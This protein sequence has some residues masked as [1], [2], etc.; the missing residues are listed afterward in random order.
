MNKI[1]KIIT[2]RLKALQREQR[3]AGSSAKRNQ[4]WLAEEL[5]V[6]DNAVSKWKKSGQIK[7]ENI[8][9]VAK[10]LGIS[11][12]HLMSDGDSSSAQAAVATKLER[13][14]SDEAE[15]LRIFRETTDDGRKMMLASLRV[16][17]DQFAGK[18]PIRA[19]HKP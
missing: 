15:M 11:I 17:L 12:D 14:D 19:R 3:D 7:S 10:A 13:L 16:T 9:S 5:G 2:D 1:G 8:P 18:S 6:S 4:A